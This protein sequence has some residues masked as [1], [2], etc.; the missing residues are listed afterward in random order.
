MREDTIL[1]EIHAGFSTKNMK[2][3]ISVIILT[4]N[5]ELNIEDCL[6]SVHGWV[7]DIFIVDSYS[8]DRTLEIVRKYTD[9]IYQHPFENHAKQF[10]WALESLPIKTEWVMRLDADER[11]TSQ[12]REK[13]EIVLAQIPKD[14]N[15]IFVKRKVYFMGKWI[16]YGGYYPIWLLRLWRYGKGYCEERWMDEHIKLTEGKYI[17]INGDIEEINKK[18]LHWW[19]NKHNSYATREAIDM[20]NLK[21]RLI[22]YD[23]IEPKLLGSQPERK[24]WLKERYSKLPLFFRPFLYFIY[25]YFIRLGFLDG[26]EGLIWHFL[27]GF[28]YRFL[29]DAK[30]YEIEKR[31][32]NERK[33]I[34]EVIKELYNIDLG[35]ERK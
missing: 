33:K 23:D 12:L 16:K 21:Y 31:A 3:P 30:I 35:G 20:L 22:P 24:R 7:E 14:V 15:G 32:K 26:I 34:T 2:L 17:F 29:V 18:E 6:K 9:K 11:V 13:L 4:Y 5:E 27:Q 8:T 1:M 10:N 28:W 19:I 25:R